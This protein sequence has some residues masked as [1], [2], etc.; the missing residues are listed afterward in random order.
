M[1]STCGQRKCLLIATNARNFFGDWH[2]KVYGVNVS[3]KRRFKK[4]P[5]CKMANLAY[6]RKPNC[7]R[8]FTSTRKAYFIL[9]YLFFIFLFIKLCQI[10]HSYIRYIRTF[11]IDNTDEWQGKRYS[12]RQLQRPFL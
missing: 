7:A 9:F 1:N 11:Y 8:I 4:V 5:P 12:F 6:V 3:C 10:I 2:D